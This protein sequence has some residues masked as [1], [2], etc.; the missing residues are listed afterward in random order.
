M[1]A[2]LA[3][4]PHTRVRLF[5]MADPGLVGKPQ[6]DSRYACLRGSDSL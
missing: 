6:L 1:V 5:F 3:V 2:S 4:S